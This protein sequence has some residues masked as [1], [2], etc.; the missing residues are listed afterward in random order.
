MIP[1][2]LRKG[3]GFILIVIVFL[4]IVTFSMRKYDL[5]PYEI[6][7]DQYPAGTSPNLYPTGSTP[8]PSKIWQIFS[9][10]AD[11]KEKQ[12]DSINPKAL[13]D[14]ASWVALNPG[15]QYQLLGAGTTSGDDFVT[16]HF[17]HDKT[18]MDTYFSLRSP[19]LKT[20]LLRYLVLW[21]EGGVYTDLDTWAIKPINTWVPEHLKA[22]GRVQAVI[23]LEWDQL[24]GEP[25]PGFGDEPSYMTHVVQF[26]QWTFVAAPGHPLLENAIQTSIK[27]IADLATTKN[28]SISDLDPNG[29]VSTPI[30][31]RNSEIRS[32]PAP[33]QVSYTY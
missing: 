19:G 26:C 6:Y 8:L 5:L 2:A 28:S 3:Q 16:K 23:G 13:G 10:P 21:I 12:S 18:I 7:L 14:A 17:S 20:D 22:E 1:Q 29:Y 4:L 31:R 27:R 24:D 25:W 33:Q 32:F 11:A 30:S 15:Y 9:T